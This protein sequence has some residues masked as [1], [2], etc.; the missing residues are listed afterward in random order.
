MLG[1]C[2]PYVDV[3]PP[4]SMKVWE[5]GN[6]RAALPGSNCYEVLGFKTLVLSPPLHAQARDLARLCGRQQQS[7]G[8]GGQEGGGQ[9]GEEAA[10]PLAPSSSSSAPVDPS[11]LGG[12]APP[13]PLPTSILP[14]F[15]LVSVQPC[16]LFPH[17]DH[18][19]TVAVLD[20]IIPVV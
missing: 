13:T 18:V 5:C 9:Q 19:E 17:T 7:Q 3:A 16:D 15:R 6:W 8:G 20:R 12:H 11:A 2:S 1:Q 10:S 14:R 4:P